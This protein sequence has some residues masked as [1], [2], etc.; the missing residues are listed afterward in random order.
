VWEERHGSRWVENKVA[1]L[2]LGAPDS[3]KHGRG[4]LP[5]LAPRRR[6]QPSVCAKSIVP[7]LTTVLDVLGVYGCG[8]P[9]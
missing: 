7:T 9:Y 5:S 3:V 6:I 2:V 1:R 4:T 8:E